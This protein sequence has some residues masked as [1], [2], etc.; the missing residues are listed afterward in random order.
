MFLSGIRLVLPQTAAPP[1]NGHESGR[2]VDQACT[3]PHQESLSS[4]SLTQVRSL[5][6]L[7]TPS[8]LLLNFAQIVGFVKVVRWI[9]Q[10]C[11]T[12]GFV[13]KLFGFVYVVTWICQ[14]CYPARAKRAGPKG[15]H[16][17][18]ARAVTGRRCPHSGQGEDFLTRQP[19]FFLQKRL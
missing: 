10:C 8:L 5:P 16:A 9:S 14:S 11:Y 18:S 17:E 13:K 4:S 2:P 12:H 3:S 19:V 1:W 7:V 6:S 15:L